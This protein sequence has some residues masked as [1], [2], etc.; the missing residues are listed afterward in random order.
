MAQ[1]IVI[2]KDVYDWLMKKKE[3]EK[4]WYNKKVKI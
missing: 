3:Q 2:Q 4:F 1:K